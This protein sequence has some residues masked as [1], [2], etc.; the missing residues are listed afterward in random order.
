M[1]GMHTGWISRDDIQRAP[2][3]PLQRRTE[4]IEHYARHGYPERAAYLRRID[5]GQSILAGVQ[6]AAADPSTMVHAALNAI[7][8]WA[9]PDVG[10]FAITD[11]LVS[12]DDVI[13]LGFRLEQALLHGL[14][15]RV[16]TRLQ[17]FPRQ[18]RPSPDYEVH[19]VL[20]ALHEVVNGTGPLPKWELPPPHHDGVSSAHVMI[21]E[22]CSVVELTVKP[23]SRCR[24][25]AKRHAMPEAVLAP[26]TSPNLPWLITGYRHKYLHTCMV[27]GAVFFGKVDAE[28]CS[29]RCRTA[30][31]RAA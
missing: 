29:A 14:A 2:L 17:P 22:L 4:L 21:C 6:A 25:C 23:S 5:G 8:W 12:G 1:L 7:R 3:D 15:A 16:N 11:F 13:H 10:R 24:L 20:R 19:R 28:T 9:G 31:H 26:I 30:R 27:C 18:L